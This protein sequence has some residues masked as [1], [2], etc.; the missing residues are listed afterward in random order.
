MSHMKKKL[1][2]RYEKNNIMKVTG[3]IDEV[4]TADV[5]FCYIKP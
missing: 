2:I 5:I 4:N 3:K 1:Y